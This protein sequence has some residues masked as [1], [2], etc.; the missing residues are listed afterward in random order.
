[1]QM[2]SRDPILRGPGLAQQIANAAW[3]PG[4]VQ[5]LLDRIYQVIRAQPSAAGHLLE[6]AGAVASSAASSVQVPPPPFP[7]L[8][9]P[10]DSTFSEES[11]LHIWW[12]KCP[13]TRLTLPFC[14]R[15][16]LY[17]FWY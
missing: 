17:L 15:V 4:S 8:Q 12:T 2:G 9:Y 16:L 14:M 6:T 5:S 1:M 13:A 7:S 11:R 3:Q 10:T